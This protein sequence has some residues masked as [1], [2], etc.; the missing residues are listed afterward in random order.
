MK[1]RYVFLLIIIILGL[2]GLI[3]L[4]SNYIPHYTELSTEQSFF[5]EKTN[6]ESTINPNF[7][8]NSLKGK[9]TLA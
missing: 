2:Q 4:N 8:N 3:I 1:I 7:N 5:P 6:Y 9:Y